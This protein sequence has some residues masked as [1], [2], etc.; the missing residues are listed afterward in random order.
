MSQSDSRS[1]G[2]TLLAKILNQCR[3]GVSSSDYKPFVGPVEVN[4][5]DEKSHGRRLFPIKDV[6]AG[7]LLIRERAFSAVFF[8]NDSID[9]IAITTGGLE[10][11]GNDLSVP[12]VRCAL[13]FDCYQQLLRTPSLRTM[14]MKLQ[15]GNYCP[16]SMLLMKVS[17]DLIGMKFHVYVK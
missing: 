15:A 9:P 16:P 4:D 14:F 5:C 8:S 6:K 13:T 2:D 1:E 17:Q 3:N 11:E 7:E 10:L 12:M